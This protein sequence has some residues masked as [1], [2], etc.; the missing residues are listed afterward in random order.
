MPLSSPVTLYTQRLTRGSCG[1]NSTA[2]HAGSPG[3]ETEIVA[4][5]GR[6]VTHYSW[7]N[8]F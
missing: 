2:R 5:P 7:V 4:P 3:P 6:D 8:G 1:V